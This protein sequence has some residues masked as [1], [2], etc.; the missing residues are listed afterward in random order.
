[1]MSLSVRFLLE[2]HVQDSYL[3]ESLVFRM[4]I[5]LHKSL[6]IFIIMIIGLQLGACA[7]H[8]PIG[9]TCVFQKVSYPVGINVDSTDK[10]ATSNFQR[11]IMASLQSR[12]TGL[13]TVANPW[14]WLVLS[15]GGQWGS[16]GAG[17]LK[18]WSDHGDRPIF[19]V[20]TGVSTGALV[21]PYAF[22]GRPYDDALMRGFQIKSE[23]EII[24][25]RGWFALL[26]SNSLYDTKALRARVLGDIKQYEMI[27]KL[28]HEEESGRRLLIGVV[29]ADNGV[30]YA[31]DLTGLAVQDYLPIEVREQCMVDYMMASAGVPVAF[32]PTF[33]EGQMLM[34]GG[35]RASLLIGDLSSAASLVGKRAVNIYVIKN[36][37]VNIR[38]DTVKNS[39]VS[40]AM[41]SAEIILDQIGDEGLRNIVQQPRLSG[42]TRFITTDI[43]KCDSDAPEVRAKLFVPKFME[44]LVDEG[45]RI[46]N[47][48]EN[49][50][51]KSLLS[52]TR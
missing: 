12:N 16:F 8:R 35:A 41:R 51:M 18:G 40:I 21:A 26:R 10:V 38:K 24:S 23:K 28:K 44:C 6:S 30:F 2:L 15:G 22:L 29:N 17:F 43:A 46:G 14:Q 52:A 20:V 31:I 42:Q 1:M 45:R 50:W 25:M 39:I 13:P 49:R 33:I 48:G 3:A 27:D 34:D 19:D 37:N 11:F 5:H 32:S 47:L 9:R 7:T 36:G 4:I